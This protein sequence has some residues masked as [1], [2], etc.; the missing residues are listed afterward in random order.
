VLFFEELVADPRGTMRS[1][2]RA[3]E[4]DP[5][6]ADRFDPKPHNQYA[7]PRNAAIRRLLARRRLAR[8]LIPAAVRRGVFKAVMTPAA[9][10]EPDPESV[11]V[12]LEVYEPDVIAL[13]ALLGRR[14]PQA[15][16]R[17][18]PRLRAPSTAGSAG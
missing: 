15:W 1:L 17:R 11:R 16:E 13:R 12:L 6:G 2:F 7:Q 4:V 18:F 14:L 10:P 5:E 9:K 3:L 8:G